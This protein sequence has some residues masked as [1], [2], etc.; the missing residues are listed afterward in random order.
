V[1]G[2]FLGD[3]IKEFCEPINDLD[4][5]VDIED[6]PEG[7]A[8]AVLSG[9]ENARVDDA[10]DYTVLIYGD[11]YFDLDLKYYLE[12]HQRSGADVSALIR[13]TDHMLDSDLV[14]LDT[15][16]RIVGLSAYPHENLEQFSNNAC[17][18]VYILNTKFFDGIRPSQYK[19]KDF[20]Q[21]LIPD[22]I[23]QG[24]CVKGI[25]TFEYI[26]D[27]GTPERLQSVAN[28]VR[29][30]KPFSLSMQRNKKI[31][32]WD[33]DGTLVDFVPYLHS[34]EQLK[35][36]EGVS[37]A[38]RILRENGF[39]SLCITN[40]PVVA[41]GE[42]SLSQLTKIH[43]RLERLLAEEKAMLDGIYFCPHHPD[44][45]FEGEILELKISCDCRKPQTGLFE[46]ATQGL[47]LDKSNCWMVGDTLSDV[48]AGQNFQINSI[49][50]QSDEVHP[51]LS[52]MPTVQL[53]QNMNQ[54]IEIIQNERIGRDNNQNTF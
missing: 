6:Q 17:C 52:Q 15:D 51:E 35:L 40:Q 4:I 9:M 53:A 1:L 46:F 39:L 14:Q 19:G 45:G 23:R 30:G 12:Q 47:N 28:D 31:V 2:G 11:V 21:N 29:S 33:R 49:L 8:F 26:K 44:R 25:K 7:T 41:R 20:A 27:M 24:C 22:L 37:D 54:V 16:F 10:S 34:P 3:I 42:V 38:L 18:G 13:A 36:K 5:T 43:S 50:F 32:F 48:Y